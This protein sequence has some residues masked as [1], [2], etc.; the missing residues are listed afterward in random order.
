M[1]IKTTDFRIS[2]PALLFDPEYFVFD[3]DLDSDLTRFL[4][5]EEEKLKLAPFIDIRFESVSQGQ[6][7]V[8]TKELFSLEGMHNIKR[9]PSVFIFHHAFVCSTLL[10]RCLN[11]VD[12][13]F[14]LKEPWILRRLAD[15]KRT[16]GHVIPRGQW[17]E[18][19]TCYLNLLAKNYKTGTTPLIKAT[20]VANNLLVDVLRYFPGQKILYL[21]SDLESFLVSNLKKPP[22]TQKKMPGLA[23]GFLSDGD[24]A[25][26]FPRFS[27]VNSLSFLQVCALIWLVNLYNF[28][29]SVEKFAPSKVK[30]LE[31]NDFLADMGG[32]LNRLSNFFGYKA[33]PAEIESMLDPGIIK[34]DAK[35]QEV[36]YGR[37]SKQ[38]E[39]VQ[40]L[41]N[42]S[43]EIERTIRWI[44]PLVEQTGVLDYCKSNQLGE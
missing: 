26:R 1:L 7:A 38:A 33:T 3:F 31:M 35:H 42:Y 10:A 21:Y 36:P 15:L 29:R 22:D 12:A 5:V 20:N 11:Q 6:F 30:T 39:V 25:Q 44:S 32:S 40:V 37:Q 4:V 34:R 28:R 43:F 14:S 24:F 18:M 9:P 17:R 27:D 16:Q 13:F 19:F 2:A 41:G 23:A 8:S